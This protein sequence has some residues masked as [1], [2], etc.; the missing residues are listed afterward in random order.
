MIAIFMIVVISLIPIYKEIIYNP[1][2][3]STN[4]AQIIEKQ[5]HIKTYSLTSVS[6][7]IVWDFGKP[8]PV[9]NG[10]DNQGCIPNEIKFGLMVYRK[11]SIEIKNLFPGYK[12][13]KVYQINLHY[14]KKK[15]DRM[16]QD[17]YLISKVD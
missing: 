7:E 5:Y 13:E 14:T 6:P 11:D 4:K 17:Y 1:D 10:K 12:I 2:F 15:K 8:I 16:I 3:A 9:I